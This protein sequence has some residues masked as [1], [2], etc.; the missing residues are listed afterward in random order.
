MAS[1]LHLDK[2]KVELDQKF[3]YYYLSAYSSEIKFLLQKFKFN[4]DLLIVPIFEKLF[5][6]WWSS[7][8]KNEHLADLDAIAVVPRHRLR[9]LYRGFNQSEVIAQFIAD[10][11]HNND[12]L[13]IMNELNIQ[14][15]SLN[16]QKNKELNRYMEYLS[17]QNQSQQSIL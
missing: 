11:I 12:F 5:D 17:L 9:Y 3:N 1:H 16:P 8:A 6:K 2:E 15:H 7:F 4:K 14:N 10:T 13:I